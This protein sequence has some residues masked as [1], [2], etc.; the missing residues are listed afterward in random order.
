MEITSSP[1]FYLFSFRRFYQAYFC[2]NRIMGEMKVT[3]NGITCDAKTSD[4]IGLDRNYFQL[5]PWRLSPK[6]AF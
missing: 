2:L 6:V 5:R 1:S 3:S 4:V